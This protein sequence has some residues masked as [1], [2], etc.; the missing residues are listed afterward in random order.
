[1]ELVILFPSPT[2]YIITFS[3][4]PLLAHDDAFESSHYYNKNDTDNICLMLLH[5]VLLQNVY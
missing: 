1:M 4:L 2:R 3:V 5:Q